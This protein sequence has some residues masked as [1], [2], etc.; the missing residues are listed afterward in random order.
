[1]STQRSA[2]RIDYETLSTLLENND[3]SKK[4]HGICECF[5]PQHELKSLLEKTR[6]E[7]TLKSHLFGD[8]IQ[9]MSDY[10]LKRAPKTFLLLV[11]IDAVKNIGLLKDENFTDENLSIESKSTTNITALKANQ[12]GSTKPIGGK[13]HE[14]GSMHIDNFFEKRWIFLV[15][16]FQQAK[17]D[18]EF[19]QNYRLP[20]RFETSDKSKGNF[21]SVYQIGFRDAHSTPTTDKK[22]K[23]ITVAL[24]Q[25]ST[26]NNLT[27]NNVDKFYDRELTT[28]KTMR[29]MNHAHLIKAIAS[30]KKGNDRCFLF[31]WADG[32]SLE[33]LW[34]KNRGGFDK[35]LIPWAITQMTGLSE[36]IMK[37]HG[38]NTRHGDIKPANILCFTEGNGSQGYMTLK[39]AD[40]GLAK[41]HEQ[42]TRYRTKPTTTNHG[43]ILYEPPESDKYRRTIFDNPAETHDTIQERIISRKYD[44]WGLGCVF[45][46]F[47]ICLVK[48]Y[49]EVAALRKDLTENRLGGFWIQGGKLHG[50]VRRRIKMMVTLVK[51]D[52]AL[53]DLMNLITK[54]L[55]KTEKKGRIESE[56]LF[57]Q[58][59]R[60]SSVCSGRSHISP[61]RLEGLTN[62]RAET[63][64][65]AREPNMPLSNQVTKPY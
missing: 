44:V 27:Y 29:D 8:D 56:M 39:I 22:G 26:D 24:K 62:Q 1:M 63:A 17:F 30:Y 20:F 52:A 53:S 64:E 21:G 31:P 42:Y 61:S 50:A 28:L 12:G 16:E 49:K 47:I 3:D 10:V 38:K 37:L 2:G 4:I 51:N 57:K 36:A 13:A 7:A 48:G 32:G 54:K 15:A 23:F 60:I 18:Y 46:E 40:V 65:S 45:L 14:F 33:A 5:L 59:M 43:T 34:K 55:L 6:V 58:M 41:V 9:A 25:M 35:D 11:Y 19:P